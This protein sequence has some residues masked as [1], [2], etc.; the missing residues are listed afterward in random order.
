MFTASHPHY[1]DVV[2]NILD[3]KREL[4]SKRLFRDS[5]IRTDN[6]LFIKDLRV[7]NRDLR[8]V[9]IVDNAIFSFA[10]QLDNGIPIIP[11]YDD[12]ED[13]IMPKIAEYLLG[14]E[15][16]E[17]VRSVNRQT[18]SL[19]ELYELNVPRF[20]KYYY[21]E[22]K[23]PAEEEAEKAANARTVRRHKSRSFVKPE[24][25]FEGSEEGI[26]IGE[27]AQAAVETQLIILRSSLPRYLASQAELSPKVGPPH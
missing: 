10:F 23:T 3:P 11:F 14:L 5:C 26:V 21:D 2:V 17:D 1:A 27:E 16:L 13:R 12:R 4:F 19:T 7:L 9:V 22:E 8:S 15:G 24:G 6:G 20:L 18:F 25:P